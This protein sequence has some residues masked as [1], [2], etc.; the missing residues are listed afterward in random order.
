MNECRNCAHP[1]GTHP[2]TQTTGY[3]CTVAG[4]ECEGFR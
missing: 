3:A 4:C 1:K 2:T